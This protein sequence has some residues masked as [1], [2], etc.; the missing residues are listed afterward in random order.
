MEFKA[1][2]FPYSSIYKILTGAILPRPIGWVSTLDEEGEAN[3]APFSF[4]NAVCPNPPTVL[5]CPT[6]R[7]TDGNPKDTL[8]NVKTTGEFVINIVS[9]ALVDKMVLT[10]AELPHEVN[11]FAY[12]KVTPEPS[13]VVKPFRVKE[14]LIH[15]ECVLRH[16]Y[17]VSSHPG[18]GSVVIGEVVHFHIDD[19]VMFGGDKI[20]LDVYKPVG[21]LAGTAYARTTDRFDIT[22]PP[23]QIEEK[24][25]D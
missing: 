21:R 7:S 18:G 19:S 10:S 20:D 2:D 13:V 8:R 17:E 14:S 5:F 1:T 6:V 23:S 24:K 4:F 22:R 3:L 25:D 16:V 15:F 11:E 12:A 9:E